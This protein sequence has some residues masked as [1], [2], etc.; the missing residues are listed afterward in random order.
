MRNALRLLGPV[1]DYYT[2][3]VKAHGPT[4]RGVDWNSAKSQSLRF[5]QLLKVCPVDK[6]FSL[7]DYGCGY[8]SLFK[9]LK[10]SGLRV[11]Y[12]G[13]DI[14]PEMIRAAKRIFKPNSNA[15]FR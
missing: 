5:E 14:S 8:G 10:S 15:K 1:R 4:A 13:F 11:R 7:Q 12:E 6:A 2:A 9:Y 3:K